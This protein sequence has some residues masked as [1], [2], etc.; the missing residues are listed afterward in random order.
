MEASQLTA[1]ALVGIL[2]AGMGC[3]FVKKR[4]PAVIMPFVRLPEAMQERIARRKLCWRGTALAAF[5]LAAAT[6][7]SGLPR[8]VTVLWICVGFWGQYRVL[9]LRRRYPMDSGVRPGK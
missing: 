8:G 6:L 2:A 4:L 1:C 5:V 9:C 3:W 7:F